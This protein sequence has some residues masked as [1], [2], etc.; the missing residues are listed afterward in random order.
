M[1]IKGLASSLVAAL[2]IVAGPAAAQTKAAC[3]E[4]EYRQLDFWVGDWVAAWDS[5]TG[6]GTGTNRI[7]RDEFGACAIVEHFHADDG[8]L[9]GLSV[10][11]WRPIEHAWRQTW[12]DDQGGYFDFHGGPGAATDGFAFRFETTPASDSAS[13]QRMVFQEV[14]PN[15]FVWRWQ[16]RASVAAAW[17]D[18][19]VIRYTRASALGKND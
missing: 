5:P 14:R 4:P 15:S 18:A 9:T 3:G 17:E 12:I 6:P 10:S 19:W 8:S 7:T 16:K 13:R 2:A 11:T 1:L